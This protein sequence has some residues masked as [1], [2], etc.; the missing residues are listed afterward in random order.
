MKFANDYDQSKHRISLGYSG[1]YFYMY[2][3]YSL[4]ISLRGVAG[5][6]QPEPVSNEPA[7]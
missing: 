7:V 2:N 4:F 1:L 3:V 6:Y 5:A